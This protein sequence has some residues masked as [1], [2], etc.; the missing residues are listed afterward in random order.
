MRRGQRQYDVVRTSVIGRATVRRAG[1]ASSRRKV[2]LVHGG[3]GVPIADA[4]IRALLD[5]IPELLACDVVIPTQRSMTQ[6]P[7]WSTA[8]DIADLEALRAALDVPAWD[9]VLGR[10]W[11]ASLCLLYR[12]AHPL[13]VRNVVAVA[14]SSLRVARERLATYRAMHARLGAGPSATRDVVLA[15]EALHPGVRR[16]SESDR[17][18]R[19]LIQTLYRANDFYLHRER[20]SKVFPRPRRCGRGVHVVTGE[21]DDAFTQMDR[22]IARRFCRTQ[23]L[24]GHG[25]DNTPRMQQAVVDLLRAL[26]AS[27]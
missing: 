7:P 17:H 20:V 14:P 9:V 5:D 13:A 15:Y 6:E 25:H 21:H 2:L 11:G 22:Y 3:P 26:L 12:A 8:I 27:P 23:T 19:A 1:T 16:L 4:T 18:R 10:S 24:L